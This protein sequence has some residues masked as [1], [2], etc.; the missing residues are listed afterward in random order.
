MATIAITASVPNMAYH[1][2]RAAGVS[3]APLSVAVPG[4][5][6]PLALDMGSGVISVGKLA[7]ARRS[8][9]RLP[10]GAALDAKGDATTDPRAASIPLPLGGPKG[11]GL[12]LLIEC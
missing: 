5:A 2:A 6:E 12:A 3:A 4:D 1:G 7:Q 11:S 10:D 8:G 9:E